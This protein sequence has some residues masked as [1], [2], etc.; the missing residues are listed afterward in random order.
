MENKLQDMEKLTLVVDYKYKYRKQQNN[1]NQV[2]G[3]M[4]K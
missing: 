4:H 1:S 2:H 3:K